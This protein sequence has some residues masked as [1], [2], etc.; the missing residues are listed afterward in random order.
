MCLCVRSIFTTELISFYCSCTCIFSFFFL[1]SNLI[2]LICEFLV[3]LGAK[4]SLEF[5]FTMICHNHPYKFKRTIIPIMGKVLLDCLMPAPQLISIDFWMI[6]V[7][8]LHQTAQ[9]TEHSVQST[10]HIRRKS[11]RNGEDIVDLLTFYLNSIS[12]QWTI[13]RWIVQ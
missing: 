5:S 4:Y 13:T 7:I 11:G 6:L 1:Y 3:H 9:G 2:A 12:H 8:E 10:V